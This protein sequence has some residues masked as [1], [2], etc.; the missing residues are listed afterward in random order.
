M[1]ALSAGCLFRIMFPNVNVPVSM[2]FSLPCR[3]W[4]PRKTGIFSMSG[5]VNPSFPC[6]KCF[7]GKDGVFSMPDGISAWLMP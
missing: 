7:P 3:N 2:F 1:S 4:F 5:S 6:R